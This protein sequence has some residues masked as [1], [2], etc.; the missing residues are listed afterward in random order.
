VSVQR[1]MKDSNKK[2]S[3]GFK[4]FLKVKCLW[5]QENNHTTDL[6]PAPLIAINSLIL[7]W[8]ILI[9]LRACRTCSIA[10]ELK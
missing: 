7:A 2:T 4:D 3:G 5:H 6:L 8:S 10:S 9:I 1:P